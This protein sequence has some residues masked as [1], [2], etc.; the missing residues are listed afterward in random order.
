MEQI[1][2]TE[3]LAHALKMIFTYAIVLQHTFKHKQRNVIETLELQGFREIK[4]ERQSK[5]VYAVDMKFPVCL[6]LNL[7]SF[8]KEPLN[9]NPRVHE[10]IVN[11]RKRLQKSM[12]ELYP[13]SLVLSIDN[14]MINQTLI[15]KIC[16]INNVSNE[17]QVPKVIGDYMCVPFGNILKGMVVPNTVTK[18]L[19]TEKVYSTDAAQFMITEY[20][21]YSPMKTR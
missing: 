5:T 17:V 14:D 4:D 8:I 6:T 1:V 11:A 10:A 16:S 3:T 2:I 13:G 19:H 9:T 7:E 15:N 12:T 21:F 18:S 20:P